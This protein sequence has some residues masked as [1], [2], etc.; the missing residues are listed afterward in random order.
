ML[1]F[2]EEEDPLR[3]SCLFVFAMNEKSYIEVVFSN[4][5]QNETDTIVAMLANIEFEGFEEND[6]CVKAYIPHQQFNEAEVKKIAE[7][8]SVLY[9]TKDVPQQ[10]WNAVWESHFEPVL[11]SDF[12]AV[13]AHFHSPVS[14]VQHEIII[15]PKMS[16]GT[17]HHATTTM[18]IEQ[19]QKINC[20]N[21]AVLDFGTGTGI[22]SI[23]AEKLG[24]ASVLAIDNDEWSINNSKENIAQNKCSK[25]K[26]EQ[27]NDAK[28]GQSF[29]V[30][31]ANINRNVILYN[32]SFLSSQL[33]KKGWL[34][35]S[36]LL[37]EDEEMICAEATRYELKHENTRHLQ[38]WISLLFRR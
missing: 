3:L 17:G 15:T 35:L 34:L 37:A 4:I 14:T 30:I 19:M 23:L 16:F 36:G 24:A 21:K 18:M 20:K 22:L 9:K 10:N 31:V 6:D 27:R 26:V 8:F 11:I 25:I 33:N 38:Q 1:L 28:I 5:K 7:Q 2:W 29:D 12:V 13:R 32:L